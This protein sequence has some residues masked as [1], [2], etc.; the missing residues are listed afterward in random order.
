MRGSILV[1]SL[2][3][4]FLV[5]SLDGAQAAT[6]LR[7]APAKARFQP[8]KKKQPIFKRMSRSMGR[9]LKRAK[10]GVQ[11]RF[12]RFVK[13]WND[14]NYHM[15]RM[16]RSGRISMNQLKDLDRSLKSQ[17]LKSPYGGLIKKYS[18]PP[19]RDPISRETERLRQ[20][21]IQNGWVD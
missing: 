4:L 7:N 21:V 17:G 3:G 6:G 16:V 5:A 15:E 13:R 2:V 9:V 14:P 10:V 1:A 11:K 8:A 18:P 20:L 12:S 19:A